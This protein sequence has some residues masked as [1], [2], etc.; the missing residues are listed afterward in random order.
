[1]PIEAAS[2]MMVAG[3]EQGY[4]VFVPE[5]EVAK[6]KACLIESPFKKAVWT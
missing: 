5:A 4:W 3:A 2:N 6:A 1:M